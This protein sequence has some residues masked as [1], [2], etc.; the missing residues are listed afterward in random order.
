MGA[1]RLRTALAAL[2]VVGL[3]AGCLPVPLPPASI[4]GAG[5]EA[6][7][8]TVRAHQNV[9]IDCA[10]TC[11]AITVTVPN[12]PNPR[13]GPEDGGS[14]AN[15]S[16]APRQ[17]PAQ[18]ATGAAPA[19]VEPEARRDPEPAGAPEPS[20]A[21]PAAEPPPLPKRKP[22]TGDVGAGIPGPG[23]DA[24]AKR[25]RAVEGLRLEP[26][27]DT[28]G[29]L[30]IG[31]GHKI[32]KPEAEKLLV[33]DMATARAAAARAV[34]P[35]VWRRLKRERRDALAEVAFAV[36]GHGVT[37]FRDMIAAVKAGSFCRAAL[38]LKDSAWAR[39]NHGRVAEIAARLAGAEPCPTTCAPT[40]P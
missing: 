23:T 19:G 12:S 9:A 40:R 5:G 32:T 34:G 4:P 8:P 35:D 16:S 22:G 27:P 7:V 20:A 29:K 33:T 31:Y 38:E 18:D 37:L 10:G 26:Y 30:H 39:Q 28:G 6:A 21:E 24:L 17:A 2:A 36:G 11:G 15:D 3:S 1:A 13:G 14:N 25:L